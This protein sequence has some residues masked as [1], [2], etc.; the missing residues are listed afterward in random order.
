MTAFTTNAASPPAPEILCVAC[1]KPLD[2]AW[3]PPL[4]AGR[5]GYYLATCR[6]SACEQR[7]FT[8]TEPQYPSDEL[9]ARYSAARK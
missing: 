3:Q 7:N 5:T 6:N 2:M 8:Y 4:I 9:L 1:L